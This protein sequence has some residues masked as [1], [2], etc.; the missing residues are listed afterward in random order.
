[1]VYL[2]KCESDDTDES[3][4]NDFAALPDPNLVEAVIDI[5]CKAMEYNLG[6]DGNFS[7]VDRDGRDWDEDVFKVF[8]YKR[9][10][11]KTASRREHMIVL[12]I[13]QYRKKVDTLLRER[14]RDEYNEWER[15]PD[16]MGIPEGV[17]P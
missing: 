11:R 12:I 8:R 7:T 14:L 16:T 10:H 2:Q 15:L 5:L 6:Y 1:M 4:P 9:K 13:R 17:V 3:A